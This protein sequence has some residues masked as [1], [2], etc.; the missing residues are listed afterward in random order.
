MLSFRISFAL[1]LGAAAAACAAPA[2]HFSP[3]HALNVDKPQVFSDLRSEQEKEKQESAQRAR[4]LA[5]LESPVVRQ[6]RDL[7]SPP[8]FDPTLIYPSQH[9][10]R[11]P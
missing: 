1:V 11:R 7:L 8:A 4:L 10:W 6:V 2:S 3:N 5:D 9:R